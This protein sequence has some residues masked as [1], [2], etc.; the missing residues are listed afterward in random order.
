MA[1]NI[2]WP[3]TDT[4][5]ICPLCHEVPFCIYQNVIP[6]Y[7][8]Q[9]ECCRVVNANTVRELFERIEGLI[10]NDERKAREW[11]TSCTKNGIDHLHSFIPNEIKHDVRLTDMECCSI[12]MNYPFSFKYIRSVFND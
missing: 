10:S 4:R 3:I 7:Y 2:N 1:P 12:S 11:I 8:Y 9:A 5:P 6:P